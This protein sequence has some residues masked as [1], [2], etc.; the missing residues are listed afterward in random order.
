MSTPAATD[1][2][3]DIEVTG[4]AACGWLGAV[5]TGNV[6]SP[7]SNDDESDRVLSSQSRGVL[8]TG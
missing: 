6:T 8:D 1:P 3:V 5:V 4:L 2:D 7:L